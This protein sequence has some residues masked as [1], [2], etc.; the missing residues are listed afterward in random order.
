MK[1]LSLMLYYLLL[2]SVFTNVFILLFYLYFRYGYY[3]KK[4][5]LESQKYLSDKTVSDCLSNGCRHLELDRNSGRYFCS[6]QTC[7]HVYEALRH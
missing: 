2:V 4:R 3:L 5:S 7:P 1:Y 6:I